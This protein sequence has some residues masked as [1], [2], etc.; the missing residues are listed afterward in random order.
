MG[1]RLGRRVYTRRCAVKA[2]NYRLAR[3]RRCEPNIQ[4]ASPCNCFNPVQLFLRRQA[5]QRPQRMNAEPPSLDGV[6]ERRDH[7][8]CSVVG[9]G[10]LRRAGSL[11]GCRTHLTL[12]RRV[13]REA[14]ARSVVSRAHV[15]S[16]PLLQPP[17]MTGGS[18]G[19]GGFG[20]QRATTNSNV[21][22][23]TVPLGLA[24]G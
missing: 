9:A 22:L 13:R 17:P 16:P 2:L 10:L 4:A 19:V 1:D 18:I 7:L 23:R 14:S 6:A 20:T 12:G 3:S 5:C 24:T 21:V 8:L 11:A 15:A